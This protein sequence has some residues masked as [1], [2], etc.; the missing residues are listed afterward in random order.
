[1]EAGPTN[2]GG[3]GQKRPDTTDRTGFGGGRVSSVSPIPATSQKICLE[4]GPSELAESGT[5]DECIAAPEPPDDD[6]DRDELELISGI[7]DDSARDG[8]I[9]LKNVLGGRL[10]P[11]GRLGRFVSADQYLKDMLDGIF[12]RHRKLQ[13]K[14]YAG[15]NLREKEELAR[16]AGRPDKGQQEAERAEQRRMSLGWSKWCRLREVSPAAADRYRAE[17]ADETGDENWLLR[18]AS[19]RLVEG[20]KIPGQLGPA[21]PATSFLVFG[22]EQGVLGQRA[23][24]TTA[25]V[26]PGEL[27]RESKFR[28]QEWRNS[29]RPPTKVR[30]VERWFST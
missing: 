10:S 26:R 2:L 28:S 4:S 6:W 21:P 22:Q 20:I 14:Q 5:S 23:K 27:K 15:L 30:P 9:A 29:D 24:F 17:H 18:F 19:L 25:T 7:E 3:V 11:A 12:A 16:Q 8:V 13:A 1:M